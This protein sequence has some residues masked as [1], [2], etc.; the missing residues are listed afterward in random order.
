MKLKNKLLIILIIL[1]GFILLNSTNCFATDQT[2][3]FSNKTNYTINLTFDYA[4][5]G[6]PIDFSLWQ[7]KAFFYDDVSQNYYLYV[8]DDA[9]TLRDRTAEDV[10]APNDYGSPLLLEVGEN[11]TKLFTFRFLNGYYS[12]DDEN[13]TITISKISHDGAY[14][15]LD[16]IKQNRGGLIE[17]PLLRGQEYTKDYTGISFSNYQYVSNSV[18]SNPP[19]GTT[20]APIVEEVETE[21]TLAQV[22]ALL[23]IVLAVIVGLIAIRKALQMLAMILTKA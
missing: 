22:V 2:I 11:A 3:D 4:P 17:I 14:S 15:S 13:K 5:Y 23:P 21:K 18:F 16:S 9:F 12:I 7:Y 6:E 1:T 8:S 19:Q 20:L 10:L